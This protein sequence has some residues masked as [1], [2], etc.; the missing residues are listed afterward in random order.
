MTVLRKVQ[1]KP[2][3]IPKTPLSTTASIE[4]NHVYYFGAFCLNSLERQLLHNGEP[5]HLSPKA[6]DVLLVLIQN[7]GC[8]VTKEKL[9]RRSEERR[10]GKECRSRW[11]R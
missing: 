10:V 9:L 7:K 2:K 3:R 1:R 6:F 11:W 4:R 8:L 5:V